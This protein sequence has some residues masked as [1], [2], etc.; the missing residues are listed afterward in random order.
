M[1]LDLLGGLGGGHGQFTLSS[2]FG[3]V[4]VQLELRDREGVSLGLLRVL[5]IQPHRSADQPHSLT[6]PLDRLRHP[7]KRQDT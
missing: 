4:Y 2:H 3:G 6:D 7:L 1:D 5:L